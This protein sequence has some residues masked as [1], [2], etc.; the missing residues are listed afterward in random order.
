[1]LE[2][3]GLKSTNSTSPLIKAPEQT[4]SNQTIFLIIFSVLLFLIIIVLILIWIKKKKKKKQK[5]EVIENLYFCK[6]NELEDIDLNYLETNTN[7]SQ[8]QPNNKQIYNDYG[9]DVQSD[10]TSTSK[11]NIL[12]LNNDKPKEIYHLIL[13]LENKNK[14]NLQNKQSLSQSQSTEESEERW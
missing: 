3:N 12:K 4:L 5:K 10:S 9:D 2:P 1:M 7:K 6:T 13:S 8:V 11:K 14:N